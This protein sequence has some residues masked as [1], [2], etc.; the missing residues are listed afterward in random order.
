MLSTFGDDIGKE[1]LKRP[2]EDRKERYKMTLMLRA[3][4]KI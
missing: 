4:S 2:E 1:R 3:S